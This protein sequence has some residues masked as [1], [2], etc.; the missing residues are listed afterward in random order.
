MIKQIFLIEMYCMQY[1]QINVAFEFLP[2]TR[3]TLKI[4]ILIRV[5]C[6][7]SKTL[8]LKKINTVVSH[9]INA[10]FVSQTRSGFRPGQVL[11]PHELENKTFS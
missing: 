6:L 10:K 1:S 9:Q 8:M 4:K 5:F 3:I 7:E 11:P 2:C